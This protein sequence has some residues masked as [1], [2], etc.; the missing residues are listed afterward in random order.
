MPIVEVHPDAIIV[1][2]LTERLA[3]AR[4]RRRELVEEALAEGIPQATIAR[5]FAL[6]PQAVSNIRDRRKE[7]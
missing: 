7:N 6:T 2:E 4:K 3:I 1:E 5:R